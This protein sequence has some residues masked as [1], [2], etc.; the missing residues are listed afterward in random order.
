VVPDAVVSDNCSVATLTWSMT[1]VTVDSSPATGINQVGTYIFDTGITTVLY[2]VTD[3]TGNSATCSFDVTISPPPPLTGSIVSQTNVACYGDSTG[4]VTVSGSG[5]VEPYEYTIDGTNYQSSATFDSLAAGSYTVTVRDVEL[6]TFDIPVTITEPASAL[7]VATAQ[8]DNICYGG[9]SGTATA[10]AGGGTSPYSYSWNTTPEQTTATATDLAAGTYTVTVTDANGCINYANVTITEPT[11][12]TI[13]ITQVNVLCAGG[14]DG[15]ATADATEGTGPYTYSWDTSPVQ[16]TATA[17][18]LSAGTYTVTVTDIN[19]C[20]NTETVQITE[21]V[22][23]ILDATPTNASCPDTEDGEISL[24]ISGGTAPYSVIWSDGIT[25]QN[26]T[27]LLPGTYSVVVTDANGCAEELDVEVDN[28]LSFNCLEIPD[29]ITPNQDGH[30]DEWIITNID[31]YPDAEV[32]VFNRWGRLVYRERN[33]MSNPWDGT[34]RGKPVPTDSYHYILDLH[35]GSNPRSG[36]IS[37]IRE[38]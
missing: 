4:S 19:G 8:T 29:I 25:T 30:N 15:A 23:L 38:K 22:A 28:N 31:M 27:G 2:E 33:I 5:G 1:G 16:T 18:G 11:E 3:D 32:R 37:V 17:T 35:D 7:T 9:T 36:V 13:T 12:I 34:F 10:T 21:P 26:R 14:T 6:I 20:I 24:E